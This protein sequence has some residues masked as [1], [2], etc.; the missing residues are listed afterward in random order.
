MSEESLSAQ[1]D[2]QLAQVDAQLREN[3]EMMAVLKVR[4]S[5]RYIKQIA[6]VP[7]TAQHCTALFA[8]CNDGTVFSLAYLVPG[9]E[10]FQEPPIPQPNEEGSTGE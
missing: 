2:E 4:E 3:A 10:W 5:Q 1:L 8:L 9:G 7:E 6:V